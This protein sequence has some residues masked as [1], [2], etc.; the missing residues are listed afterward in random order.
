MCEWSK[1][2][3]R[4]ATVTAVTLDEIVD[5]MFIKYAQ[6]EGFMAKQRRQQEQSKQKKA[7]KETKKK[8]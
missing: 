7:Q 2:A 8:S 1:E 4:A 5:E 3:K 6:Q